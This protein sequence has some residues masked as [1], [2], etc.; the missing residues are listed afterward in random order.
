MQLWNPMHWKMEDGKREPIFFPI[1]IISLDGSYP[2]NI[3]HML[4]KH[5]PLI[6]DRGTR[7][8]PSPPP[9]SC[10]PPFTLCH[11]ALACTTGWTKETVV[12]NHWNLKQQWRTTENLVRWESWKLGESRREGTTTCD[13]SESNLFKPPPPPPP[14]WLRHDSS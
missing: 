9:L 10:I 8:N 14:S 2:P 11:S 13:E 5:K 7:E 12:N 6:E 3:T 1:H 4:N